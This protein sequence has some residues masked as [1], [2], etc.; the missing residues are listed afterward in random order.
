MHSESREISMDRSRV[1]HVFVTAFE[2]EVGAMSRRVPMKMAVL[3]SLIISA[4]AFFAGPVKAEIIFNGDFST[5][6]YTQ[7]T[8]PADSEV[9]FWAVPHYGRPIQYGG[10]NSV[11]VGNGELMSLVSIDGRSVNGINYPKGPTRGRSPFAARFMVKS[12]AGGGI[13]TRDCDPQ[14]NCTN[15]RAQID[16]EDIMGLM[17][18]IPHRSER[19]MSFSYYIPADFQSGTSGFGPVLTGLKVRGSSPLSAYVNLMLEGPGG[20]WRIYHRWTDALNPS[21]WDQLPWWQQMSYDSQSPSATDGNWTDTRDFPDVEKSRQAL[22]SVLKGGWTDW[23]WHW[24]LDERGS[25]SGGSG[26]FKI[27]KREGSGPWILVVDIRPKVTTRGGRR[28]AVMLRSASQISL[29]AASSLGKCPRVL[30]ILRSRLCR[31]SMALVV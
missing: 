24:K 6:N 30:M 9:Y 26:F 2:I 21:S 18:L 15:R 31:L 19:W 12:Q 28:S 8:K 10:Q 16:G 14:T 3:G 27:W 29:V 5:G 22:G 1:D 7:W 13:E 25:A 20:T 4:L 11:H 17:K 23:I